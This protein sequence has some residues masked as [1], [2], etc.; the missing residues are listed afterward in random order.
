MAASLGR[1]ESVRTRRNPSMRIASLAGA[2]ILPALS[3]LAAEI[4]GTWKLDVAKSKLAPT[5]TITSE[6]MKIVETAP[7]VYRGI[8]DETTKTG[9]SRHIEIIRY[10]DGK[11]HPLEG[12]NVPAGYVEVSKA[13]A[14]GSAVNTIR[15]KD[16][17]VTS[18]LNAKISPDGK[19]MTV[20]QKG[21][22]TKGEAFDETL[23]FERQ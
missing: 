10:D 22:N 11:E 15:K 20:H 12:V 8:F 2:V 13:S 14:D 1:T 5:A 3:L 4:T 9:E 16:G 17:R 18:E 19:T 23:L 21:V 7:K 6:T